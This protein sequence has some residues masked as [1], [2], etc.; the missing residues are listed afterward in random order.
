MSIYEGDRIQI[1]Q[2][3][4]NYL[5]GVILPADEQSLGMH[6]EPGLSLV[7]NS[8]G[9]LYFIL[10]RDN[11]QRYVMF[12]PGQNS[13]VVEFEEGPT[14]IHYDPRMD[15]FRIDDPLGG[16]FVSTNDELY[17]D[18]EE[19]EEFPL[20]LDHMDHPIQ[21]NFN[22]GDLEW[23][24]D[25][26]LDEETGRYVVHDWQGRAMYTD[27][28]YT[29]A[30]RIYSLTYEYLDSTPQ[31]VH[32]DVPFQAQQLQMHRYQVDNGA[33]VHQ[34]RELTRMATTM[35]AIAG[36]IIAVIMAYQLLTT[37]NLT[38]ADVMS[39]ISFNRNT[40]IIADSTLNAPMVATPIPP[41]S[42]IPANNAEYTSQDNLQGIMS[43]AQRV[44]AHLNSTYGYTVP[45]EV[46]WA[47]LQ[48]ETTG[49]C[50]PSHA[51]YHR[52]RSGTVAT[53]GSATTFGSVNIYGDSC[54]GDP[55]QTAMAQD[56]N[57]LAGQIRGVAQFSTGLA[58]S[59]VQG[60]MY[61]DI[62]FDTAEMFASCT[63]SLGINDRTGRTENDVSVSGGQL[64]SPQLQPVV[65]RAIVGDSTCLAAINAAVIA[66]RGHGGGSLL[67]ESGWHNADGTINRGVLDTVGARYHGACTYTYQTESG[68]VYAPYCDQIWGLV[69]F[70]QQN[71][72]TE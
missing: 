59:L 57:R 36:V 21:V 32:H 19:D 14:P 38:P 4:G 13:F 48:N 25:L 67:S 1:E 37:M 54:T 53:L 9:G 27:I 68:P 6:H 8:N 11:I 55:N 51:E 34:T 47:L 72:P 42:T 31:L 69:N 29:K 5:N 60:T 28:S 7:A 15:Q 33:E 65:S 63:Q 10:D 39:D 58:E 3:R 26:F 17:Q 61:N 46:T 24:S 62:N 18:G 12:A 66:A 52:Y 30:G 2:G 22:D 49:R 35:M 20:I 56:A 71:Y 16:S 23:E 45:W 44:S 50:A 40:Q 70:A 41:P 43:L 64:I